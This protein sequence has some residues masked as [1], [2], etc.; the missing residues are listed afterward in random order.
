MLACALKFDRVSAYYE[1]LEKNKVVGAF[2]NISSGLLLSYHGVYG[3]PNLH[4]V[5]P[6]GSS[7]TDPQ[8]C[9]D[10]IHSQGLWIFSAAVIPRIANSICSGT[11][12]SC[13]SGAQ[14]LA[15]KLQQKSSNLVKPLDKYGGVA[16][17]NKSTRKRML[18]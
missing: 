8:S 2:A 4:A 15:R 18:S 1:L 14:V 10:Q 16:T 17:K 3:L 11:G 13:C 12:T 5:I 9:R 6:A 7:A